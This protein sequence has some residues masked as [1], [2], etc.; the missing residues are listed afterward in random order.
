MRLRHCVC[1]C[2]KQ[3]SVQSIL[4]SVN[5]VLW[6]LHY[7]IWHEG[8]GRQP[9]EHPNRGSWHWCCRLMNTV[10]CWLTA[11]IPAVLARE[12]RQLTADMPAVLAH[13]YCL[14]NVDIPAVMTHQH[15]YCWL[16]TS[17]LKLINKQRQLTANILADADS[18]TQSAD[19]KHPCWCWLTNT[20]SWL[21]TSLLMLTHKHRQLTADIPSDADSWPSLAQTMSPTRHTL[22]TKLDAPGTVLSNS[23][24]T[25]QDRNSKSIGVHVKFISSLNS[26]LKQLQTLLR[27]VQSSDFSCL[28]CGHFCTE[29]SLFGN[30]F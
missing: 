15:R 14:L 2:G 29:L 9:L 21:Q 27:H 3:L 20:V 4:F 17:L 16:Q 22:G 1:C 6:C 12:Y 11:D 18:Q 25:I 13:E 23:S 8:W 5:K 19:C 7:I 28:K 10:S 30:H 26:H 24:F